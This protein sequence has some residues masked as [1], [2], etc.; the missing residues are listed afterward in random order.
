[1]M[2]NTDFILFLPGTYYAKHL[3]FY[4]GLC[5]SHVTVAVDGG[6]RFFDKTGLVPHVLIGDLD[7][8]KTPRGRL[9]SQT[10]VVTY[11]ADKDKTDLHLALDYCLQRRSRTIDVVDPA[12]GELDHLLGNAML[13]SYIRKQRRADR[14]LSLRLVNTACE[15]IPLLDATLTLTDCKG[16]GV[17]VLPISDSIS[18]TCTGTDYDCRA[19]QIERGHSRS[20]RNR[21]RE[22]EARV[23]VD[24]EALVIHRFARK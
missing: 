12:A 21:V 7:S 18:L 5:R 15:I 2:T 19:L 6:Y 10:A 4:T 9:S 3:D 20:L 11:P 1:M 23:R 22:P 17:S 13:L 16:H 8:L 14:E 24:G